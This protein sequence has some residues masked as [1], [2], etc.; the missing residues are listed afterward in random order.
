MKRIVT[1]SSIIVIVMASA[2]TSV[3][4]QQKK[5]RR[6]VVLILCD[7]M[8]A[9]LSIT[10]TPAI[11]TAT[12]DAL[13]QQGVLFTNAFSS[14]ASCS[15]SRSSILT[16]MYPHSNGH[17]R[18]TYTPGINAPEKEFT[19]DQEKTYDHVGVWDH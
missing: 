3:T 18:N 2:F 13:A 4:I 5:E 7:D 8:G 6:G 16:G 12:A 19:R 11:E 1:I 14:C 10:G 15:P 9:H 17:W